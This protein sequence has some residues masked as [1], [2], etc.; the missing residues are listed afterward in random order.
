M[1][2]LVKP[3]EPWSTIGIRVLVF[4]II[5]AIALALADGIM[6]G[7]VE[8]TLVL[9]GRN[10]R[11]V[12]VFTMFSTWVVD[13]RYLAEQAVYAATMFFVG[14]KFIETRTIFTIGFDKVDAANVSFKGP[15][16]NNIVWVGHRYANALEAE[17]VAEAFAERLKKSA[18]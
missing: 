8:N 5:A 15:D 6:K 1:F 2:S 14:A 10:P 9:E 17:A 18:A 7:P 4:S 13:F 12:P 16:E 3:N 11:D